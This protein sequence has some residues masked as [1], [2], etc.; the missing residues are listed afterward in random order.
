MG[1]DKFLPLDFLLPLQDFR[2]LAG[3][4]HL[5]FG[6]FS[7]D[8]GSF[9]S[10]NEKANLNDADQGQD[11]SKQREHTRISRHWVAYSTSP[12]IPLLALFGIG[13]G[14]AGLCCLWQWWR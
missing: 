3:Y 11:T 12:E 5:P 4:R 6:G 13:F 8:C 7:I 14:M 2:L 9:I 1:S 10:A